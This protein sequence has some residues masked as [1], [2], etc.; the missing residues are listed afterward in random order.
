METS[1]TIVNR[2]AQSGLITYDL[3][4]LKSKNDSILLDMKDYLFKELLLREKDFRAFVK[5]HDWSQYKDKN[6]AII[7]SSDAIVPSWA[8]IL[9]AT[10]LAPYA[11]EFVYGDLDLLETITFRNAIDALDFDQFKDER[12]IIKGCADTHIPESAFI[13]FSTRLSLVAKNIMYGE[14]CS[15]VPIFKRKA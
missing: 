9:I 7:C 12:V 6:V 2:V 10:K 15:S 4:T 11:S 13:H 1:N 8:Y 5:E 3:A 14:A